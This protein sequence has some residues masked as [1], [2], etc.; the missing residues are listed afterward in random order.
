MDLG[1]TICTPRS[2]ACGICPLRAPCRARAAGTAA[3]LPRKTPKAVK[4]VRQGI[5]Y[6]ARTGTGHWLLE[7]RPPNGLLG[8]M[9]GWPTTGWKPEPPEP[10]P[11]FAADWQDAGAEVRH[12]F[13]HFHLVL[14]VM[15]VSLPEP[16]P[17]DRGDWR[18]KD[19]FSPAALPTLMRKVFD[20][21]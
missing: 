12:T 3:E 9:L 11:P 15:V 5:A 20:M 18:D 19:S 7:T 21:S 13:T 1:A 2:P 17:A 14:R 8:G 16:I 4:P 10:A 6:V